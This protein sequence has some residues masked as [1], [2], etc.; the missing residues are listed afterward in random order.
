MRY[1]LISVT[2]S[3]LNI[4]ES[5]YATKQEAINAMKEDMELS[6]GF[7]SLDEIIEAANRG[8]AGFS[9]DEAWA[10]T[11]DQGTGQWKIIELP[12]QKPQY[13]GITVFKDTTGLYT[14][15]ECNDDNLTTL[16]FPI[17]LVEEYAKTVKPELTYKEFLDQYCA[18]WTEGLVDFAKK[19][20][21]T[22]SKS[23]CTVSMADT[24]ETKYIYKKFCDGDA[25]GEE[26]VNIYDNKDDAVTDL[27]ADVEKYFGCSWDKLKDRDEFDS[28][29]R[30]DYVCFETGNGYQF[31]IIE[32]KPVHKSAV[33]NTPV[34]NN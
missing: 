26:D 8:E 5:F 32:E 30:P 14:D 29:L 9:D 13:V 19:H 23:R 21:F 28:T 2:R 18:D 25:Y 11:N 6:C 22:I 31:F 1:V 24:P 15:E 34:Q 4:T 27:R 12:I 33:K 20:G 3:E 7:E 17:Y 10:E 16:D